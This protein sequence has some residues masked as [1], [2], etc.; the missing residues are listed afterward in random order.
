[1]AIGIIGIVVALIIFLYG[2]YRNVSVMWLAP[3]CGIIVAVTNG[4]DPTNAFT[5]YYV[6]AVEENAATGIW[7]IGGL[8]GMLVSI[9][10]TVFLGGI[11]G[12]VLTDCGAAQ[13]IATTIVN[14]FVFTTN[15]KIKMTRRAVLIM[16][17]IEMVLSYGG[18][19]AFVAI[20]AT[21]PIAIYMASRIGIPRR[22]VPAILALSCG[23]SGAPYIL[24]VHNIISMNILGTNA[25]A[26]PIPGFISLAVMEVGI[27]FICVNTIIKAMKKGETFEYGPLK[28]IS[29][30][31]EVKLPNFVV[32]LIPLVV[33][34]LLFAI[35]QNASLALVCGII[36]TIVLMAPYFKEHEKKGKFFQWGSKVIS[37][38]NE[39]A[40][41]GASALMT[42]CA[43]AGFA[44]VVQ[45]T[46]AFNGM[47]GALFGISASPL[48]LAT[49]LC[50]IIVAFTSSPPATL[51]I[52]LPM[53]AAAF[54]WTA[55]PTLNPAALHRVSALAVQTFETL[56]VNGMILLTTGLCQ[57][58][59]KDAYFPMF[60]QSVVMT[61]AGT[62]L[63]LVILMIAPGLA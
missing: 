59:I 1:M 53:V 5:G 40:V 29:Q 52:A 32:S 13:S 7:S 10:P 41:N 15:D 38:I 34:F 51:S 55:E 14:R 42:L 12:K 56:P 9:F 31:N 4:L 36:A 23:A 3:L 17:I 44:A 27:Y 39:G 60:L 58:K 35:V 2:A 49:V 47:V 24:S 6:G 11:F 30:D 18:V 33:V 21:F 26:A 28:A 62:V 45:H 43:A 25:G 19:D 48:I 61:T 50:I 63:C 8:C 16:L 54:I 57:V 22:Y 20:F 46:E 37:S